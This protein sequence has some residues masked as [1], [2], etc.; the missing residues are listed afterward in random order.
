MA[1]MF[2]FR[3]LP[4]KK[5]RGVAKRGGRRCRNQGA[6]LSPEP[7][8]PRHLFAA[9]PPLRVGMNLENIVDWSPAWVFKDAFLSS[10]GWIAHAIDTSTGGMAAWD[11]GETRPIAVDARGTPTGLAT[12]TQGGRTLRQAAGT[13][14]FRDTGGSHPAGRWRAEWDGT[15][16]VNFDFDARVVATGRTADGHAF[17]DLD[18]TPTDAGIHVVVDHTAPADPV[19]NIHLW[20]P[21]WQ[22]QSFA[23]Q[24]WQPGDTG[25][26]FHPLF[27]ERLRPFSVLRFMALQETNGSTIQTWADRRP[28]DAV[29]QG[30]GPGG[31]PG[32]PGV[33]GMSLEYMVQLAN[34]LDANPWFNMPHAADDDFVRRFA[35]YVHEHLEPGRQVHVEWANEVWN[36]AWGFDAS[37][38]VD[39]QAQLPANAGLSHW[40]VAGREAKR[41][42]DIWS[43]VFADAPGRL[44][45]I[46]A[47]W[48][49]NEWVTNEIATAMGGSFD[50]I[51][52]APYMQPT[53]EQRAAYTSATTVQQ[54]LADTRGSIPRM[55]EEVGRHRRIAADWSIRTGHPIRVVAYE[56]GPHLDGRS[57]PY[58]DAFNAAAADRRM[59]DITREY[60]RAL[61]A[62]G[63]DLYVHFQFTGSP[64]AGSF[65][66]FGTLHRMDEPTTTAWRYSAVVAAADG[67]LFRPAVRPAIDFDGDGIGDLLWRNAKTGLVTGRLCDA[68][69]GV[70]TVR[71]FGGGLKWD[72]ATVG[73]FDGDGVSD[74]AWRSVPVGTTVLWLMRADGSVRTS[75]TIGVDATWRIETSDDYDG[76][77]R[78]D[79]VWWQSTTGMTVMWLMDGL[80][81]RLT[82][83]LGNVPGTR[84][85]STSGRYDADG[86]GRADLLWRNTAN[87]L[88]EQWLMN[89]VDVVARAYIGGTPRWQVAATGDFNGDGRGDILW[90]DALS[91]AVVLRLMNVSR[92]IDRRTIREAGTWSV[93]ATLLRDGRS[94]IVWREADSGVTE[95]W[96]M[97]GTTATGTTPL[98]GDT[99][100]S[101]V[102]RPGRLVG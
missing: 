56:G 3:W 97:L 6:A 59:G 41:D 28:A 89:G 24:R 63:L 98:G 16:T 84:L 46:A 43:D 58:Q 96:R 25:S 31:S 53:D 22:G 38:W 91:G 36:F 85:V 69:G 32:E 45:R 73:D 78:D 95:A 54:V 76:D 33:N 23:G 66:D 74:L 20:M 2:R 68:A 65:G 8:E 79:L 70:K 29:R 99:L 10:R 30:S 86:D 64:Y 71:V 44:V 18:V 39:A 1:G 26:P 102:R 27:L 101:V 80:S 12:W 93:V 87:G 83:I 52:I 34:D 48:S 77:G 21:D 75:G 35:H 49:A 81:T 40:Q 62:A 19:R 50:A 7:L 61:D 17:A 15:G 47:G 14:L 13:L 72:V 51:A 94:A 100:R 57:A 60:L 9:D 82:R 5:T 55:V 37:R 67:S 90:R 4:Q 42:M 92:V 11:V 88:T